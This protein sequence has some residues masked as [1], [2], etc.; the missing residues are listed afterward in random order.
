MTL[1]QRS[2]PNSAARSILTP[3]VSGMM[4]TNQESQS[5]IRSGGTK[6]PEKRICGIKISGKNS[7][8][9][10]ADFEA[11]PTMTPSADDAHASK[12]TAVLN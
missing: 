1:S 11:L 8:A 5:G 10:L 7:M 2:P 9:V 6:N 4:Y 12:Y 3:Y